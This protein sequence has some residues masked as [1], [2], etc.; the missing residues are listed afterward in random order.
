MVLVLEKTGS[1]G[2]AAGSVADVIAGFCNDS[3]C[4]AT[5]ALVTVKEGK[6]LAENVATDFEVVEPTTEVTVVTEVDTVVADD[7]TEELLLVLAVVVM[8]V[9]SFWSPICLCRSRSASVNFCR[10]CFCSSGPASGEVAT[11]VDRMVAVISG[12]LPVRVSWSTSR[13]RSMPATLVGVDVADAAGVSLETVAAAVVV[14]VCKIITS[15]N[16]DRIFYS[17]SSCQSIN[18]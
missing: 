13:A 11:S 15:N 9:P 7:D 6:V 1:L 18:Q 14:V 5:P 17:A 8:V 12:E 3:S 10:I 16:Y 2:L 4:L